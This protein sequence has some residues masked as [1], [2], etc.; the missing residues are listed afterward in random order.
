MEVQNRTKFH[1]LSLS[2]DGHTLIFLHEAG[3]SAMASQY[4]VPVRPGS[5]PRTSLPASPDLKLARKPRQTIADFRDWQDDNLR[6]ILLYDYE[7]DR[8]VELSQLAHWIVAAQL[9]RPRSASELVDQLVTASGDPLT[10]SR[11]TV[12][13]NEILRELLSRGMLVVAAQSDGNNGGSTARIKKCDQ[14][15]V[16]VCVKDPSCAEDSDR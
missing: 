8:V 11:L 2:I 4:Y 3:V 7:L 6:R 1:S 12:S 14:P 5:K 10:R 13:V 15:Q 9:E 16:V